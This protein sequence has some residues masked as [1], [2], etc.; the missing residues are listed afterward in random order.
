MT[1]DGSSNNGTACKGSKAKR[2]TGALRAQKE[3]E[4]TSTSRARRAG[5]PGE[6]WSPGGASPDILPLAELSP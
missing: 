1:S 4:A 6:G 3:W 5:E 2:T